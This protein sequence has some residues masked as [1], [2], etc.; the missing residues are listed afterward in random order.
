MRIKLYRG[1]FYAVWSDGGET[2]R[3]TLRTQDR[4]EAVRRL[5]DFGRTLAARAETVGEIMAG[6]L[7][8]LD[9]RARSPER[10]RD[11]WKALAPQFGPLR[12]D[13]VTREECRAYVAGRRRQGRQDGTI[14]KELRT[15]RA[16]L[17][18]ANPQTAAIV[19][20]PAN[21]PPRD[22]YLT[23]A[24]Y[25]RLL[26]GCASP[27]VR[28]FVAVALATAGR[29]AA[30]LELTWTRVD[31]DRGLIR[32]WDGDGGR[33]GRATVPMTEAV[34]AVL[35]EAK[36]AALTPYVVEY[37][38]GRVRSV[39]KAFERAAER[40]GLSDVTPHVLRHTA[41]VWLAEAGTPMA[42][43]ARYLGHADSRI[44]ERV[45]ARYSPDYLRGAARA[46]EA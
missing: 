22:R 14:N 40:A 20:T 15:L 27:H 25:A 42:E 10:A 2:R 46:L 39:K 11:A 37:A 7:D 13:Q 36:A 4:D 21:P 41:A 43:I 19:E 35:L 24:E 26:A 45:Y 5:A 32:L 1:W 23:R 31:F 34:R 12:P 17:R 9:K 30:I 44:T 29:A 16:G 8:D 33:K 18:W 6:Y 28:V 38:G 3:A